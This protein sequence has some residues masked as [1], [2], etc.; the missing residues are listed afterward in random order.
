MVK[1]NV[2]RPNNQQEAQPEQTA[3]QV[4]QPTEEMPVEEESNK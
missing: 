3:E 1:G 4:E 2:R